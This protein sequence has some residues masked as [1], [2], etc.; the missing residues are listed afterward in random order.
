MTT[1]PRLY[2]FSEQ[3]AAVRALLDAAGLR[4]GFHGL[5]AVNQPEHLMGLDGG[6]FVIVRNHPRPVPQKFMEIVERN[7]M[8]LIV[9]SDEFARVKAK[10]RMRA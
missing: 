6:T 7:G 8:C 3:S 1:F 5:M 4:P 10:A 2:M 9:L